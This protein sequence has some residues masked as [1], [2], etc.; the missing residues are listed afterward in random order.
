MC[1]AFALRS[2]LM[3][4]MGVVYFN[5]G[6]G[7]V[8]SK[9]W[10]KS[11]GVNHLDLQTACK[12]GVHPLKYTAAVCQTSDQFIDAQRKKCKKASSVEACATVTEVGA[13]LCNCY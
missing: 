8:H 2:I 3:E 7:S 12:V 1:V 13:S 4:N 10:L 11:K 6:L 5:Q 9:C